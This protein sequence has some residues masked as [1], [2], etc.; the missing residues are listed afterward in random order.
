MRTENRAFANSM[1]F[2]MFFVI[3]FSVKA[4][5]A[6]YYVSPEGDDENP[7]TLSHPFRTLLRAQEAVRAEVAEGLDADIQVVVRE[8]TY[9]LTEPLVLGPRDCGSDRFGVVYKAFR[10]ECVVISGGRPI[11]GWRKAANGVWQTNIPQVKNGNWAFRQLFVD[12]DRAVRARH[13]NQ[14]YLRV[15]KVGADRR[16]HFQ[17]GRG[18][19]PVLSDLSGV[20]LVFLH[21]WSISRVPIKNIERSSRTLTVEHQIGGNASWAVMDWFEKQPRYYLENSAA[22]LDSPG[23]WCLDT[24]SGVLSYVPLP[25]QDMADLHVVAPVTEQLVVV[26]GNEDRPAKNVHFK[27]L[28]FAHTAWQ[29]DGGVYWGRQACTYWSPAT[30]NRERSHDPASPATVHF[31]R[32]VSCSLEGCEIRNSG[33]SAVWLGRQCENCKVSGCYVYDAGGNGVMIGEGQVRHIEGNPWWETAPEQ[34]ATANVV[35]NS[36]VEDCGRELFGAVGVWVGLAARTSITNNEIRA[37]P[38]TGVSVGWMW[39]NPRSR[40]EPRKTPA[41][42]NVVA[43]NHIHDIMRV[44]SDGGGIYTLGLQPDSFLRGNVIHGIPANVGRAESNGMFL[45]QGTGGF[46]I[47]DNVIYDVDRSPLRFHKGYENLVL[48]NVLGV[49]K[50]V[51]VVRYNDTKEERIELQGNRI[52]NVEE[53]TPKTMEKIAQHALKQAGLQ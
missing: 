49:R 18:D 34:A 16:T 50:G 14:G 11:T 40:P 39:W 24:E 32:A 42:Q 5:A 2:G 27:G 7:G 43:D 52:I 21:D 26:R 9:R 31:E 33:P 47:E 45:D 46:V 3:L 23:E 30:A 25:D 15:E 28:T 12:G 17:F 51:P 1:I 8:G 4:C 44:L 22:F 35:C 10:G 36:L 19:I 48:N 38:Y 53:G 13:P 29:P 20:E 6:N 41:R 37:L